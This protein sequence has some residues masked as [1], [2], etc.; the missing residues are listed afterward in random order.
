M[1]AAGLGQSVPSV[2]PTSL[3]LVPST[4]P[5]PLGK[6]RLRDCDASAAVVDGIQYRTCKTHLRIC[7]TVECKTE[8]VKGGTSKRCDQ[9]RKSYDAPHVPHA[10][11]SKQE[12]G[13]GQKS[14]ARADPPKNESIVSVQEP[15]VK[16]EPKQDDWAKY[17]AEHKQRV[18]ELI[19]SVDLRKE[20]EDKAVELGTRKRKFD[21]EVSAF[22]ANKRQR[23]AEINAQKTKEIEQ[24]IQQRQQKLA[25]VEDEN[26]ELRKQRD[27]EA[28]KC[29]RLQTKINEHE[30]DGKEKE[31]Q[32]KEALA[33]SERQIAVALKLNTPPP[34]S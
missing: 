10:K 22:E 2:L 20:L 5:A 31:L 17:L 7:C 34:G 3:V 25:A 16:V 14:P 28:M 24:I 13:Q 27:A 21:E 9:C 1:A 32:F 4:P 18:G 12:K 6:C 23:V 19:K 33:W 11:K 30:A 29:C 26:R 15:S 8:L